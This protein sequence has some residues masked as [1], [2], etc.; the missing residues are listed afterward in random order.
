MFNLQSTPNP[1][2]NPTVSFDTKF[3]PLSEIMTDTQ[4]RLLINRLKLLMNE[5]ESICG[6]TS[7]I[8]PRVPALEHQSTF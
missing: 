2:T 6:T 8:T 5:L 7:S 4:T 1:F 3:L